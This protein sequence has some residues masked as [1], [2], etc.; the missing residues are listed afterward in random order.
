MSEMLTLLSG[1]WPPC[2]QESDYYVL[3]GSGILQR[4]STILLFSSKHTS[5]LAPAG[6]PDS[7]V[8]DI[9]SNRYQATHVLHGSKPARWTLSAALFLL[10][11][12]YD[13]I[14][15]SC[16]RHELRRRVDAFLSI[17][18]RG[19]A[20]MTADR[21]RR[22]L[23][24][25]ASDHLARWALEYEGWLSLFCSLGVTCMKWYQR[26]HY[27]LMP[28]NKTRDWCLFMVCVSHR[29]SQIDRD[30]VVTP[31]TLIGRPVSRWAARGG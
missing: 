13:V 3:F 20:E 5:P 27:V 19:G 31:M 10:E 8:I 23:F 9:Y 17:F 4:V 14:P 22:P 26:L 16:S 25:Y 18:L 29:V 2:L 15:I 30:S 7:L 21:P 12:R 28:A 11:L 6:T 1:A 24:R